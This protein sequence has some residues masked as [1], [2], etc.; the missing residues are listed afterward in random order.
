MMTL[1]Q[2]VKTLEALMIDHG[3][4][5]QVVFDDSDYG[6]SDIT[7][8]R[9]ERREVHGTDVFEQLVIIEADN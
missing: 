2:L 6:E 5:I 4:D 8:V 7:R 9:V 1:K 3:E